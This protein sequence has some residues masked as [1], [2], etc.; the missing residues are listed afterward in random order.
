MC[1]S[2]TVEVVAVVVVVDDDDDDD[3][4]FPLKVVVRQETRALVVAPRKE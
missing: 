4:V 2:R 3:D 1:L